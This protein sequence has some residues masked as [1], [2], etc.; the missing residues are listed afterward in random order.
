MFESIIHTLFLPKSE[1]IRIYWIWR[2]DEIIVQ[3]H[4][5]KE[6]FSQSADPFTPPPPKYF[7]SEL[8]NS[9]LAGC[10]AF[11]KIMLTTLFLNFKMYMYS[12]LRLVFLA[13]TK[14]SDFVWERILIN[15][16][17]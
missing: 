8:Q 4:N 9:N 17:N 16:D 13:T 5:P 7:Q 15:S 14:F 12:T 2:S 3:I 1:S 10:I 6:I 11:G